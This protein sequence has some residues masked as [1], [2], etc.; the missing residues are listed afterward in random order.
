MRMTLLRTQ[1]GHV[2]IAGEGLS[3]GRNSGDAVSKED[4]PDFPWAHRPG[5]GRRGR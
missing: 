3:V 2:A 5:G 4:T 1:P